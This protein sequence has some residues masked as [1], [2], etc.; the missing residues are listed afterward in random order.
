MREKRKI[1]KRISKRETRYLYS[2][3]YREGSKL[4]GSHFERQQVTERWERYRWF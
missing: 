3:N 1:W 2:E 4:E